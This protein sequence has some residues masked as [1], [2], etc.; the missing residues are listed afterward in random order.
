M[1]THQSPHEF[2]INNRYS[3]D[4]GPILDSELFFTWPEQ[5]QLLESIY[6]LADNAETIILVL[7]TTG[8]GKTT[9][10]YRIYNQIPD[11]WLLCRIEAHP[12][13]H[14]YQLWQ[15]LAQQIGIDL[16]LTEVNCEDITNIQQETTKE[17][18]EILTPPSSPAFLDETYLAHKLHQHFNDL[19]LQ[20]RLPVIMI[21][22]ADLMP[23]TTLTHLLRLH[24]RIIEELYTFTLILLAKPTLESTLTSDDNYIAGNSNFHYLHLPQITTE[25][26]KPYITHFLSQSGIYRIPRWKLGRF[27]AIQEQTQGLPKQIN[28]LVKT[29]IRE[30]AKL[31]R[32]SL[33]SSALWL[34]SGIICMGAFSFGLLQL[35]LT[36]ELITKWFNYPIQQEIKNDL[37][38]KT[39]PL[40]IPLPPPSNLPQLS[41][42]NP[43]PNTIPIPVVH[44]LPPTTKSSAQR[45]DWILTQ[46]STNYTLQINNAGSAEE[47][48]NYIAN[49]KLTTQ[50]F[51]IEIM[52]QNQ[53]V[54][55]VLHGVY[56]TRTEANTAISKLPPNLRK[57]KP[58]PVNLGKL[59]S[60]IHK[61]R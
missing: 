4:T 24:E 49:H 32:T 41:T 26:T 21:D 6:R 17:E 19:R 42:P 13:L 56:T 5:D 33:L 8:A 36:Q 53:L 9:F 10:A 50:A 20:G 45:N 27:I 25:Q 52:E 57:K 14:I 15:K 40:P 11:H 18:I 29:T 28:A 47:A 51:Y 3:L 54:Y 23:I 59:Q 22:D 39:L 44:D 48:E 58:F 55:Y 46:P 37:I 38:L 2:I 43:N 30:D 1:N 31:P 7:G 60:E 61:Q 34:F 12:L 16:E 35:K